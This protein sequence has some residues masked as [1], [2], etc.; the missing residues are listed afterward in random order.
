ML[1]LY[2]MVFIPHMQV[3]LAAVKQL[4][5]CRVK[6]DIETF[7]DRI[8]AMVHDED[9][10]VRKQIMHTI[11]DGSPKHLEER[12]VDALE[13]FNRDADGDIRRQTHKVGCGDIKFE[14]ASRYHPRCASF[15]SLTCIG[16]LELQQLAVGAT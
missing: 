11:C 14:C 1:L 13:V 7:W 4:C 16:A 5:P 3:R 8:F 2:H 9:L 6:E 12:V 10:R 15:R